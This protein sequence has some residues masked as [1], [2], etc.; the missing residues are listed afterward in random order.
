MATAQERKLKALHNE[1]FLNVRKLS[2][3]GFV[4][5]AVTVLF[6]SALHWMRALAAPEGFQ[7]KGYKDEED[8]FKGTGVFTDEAYE[9]YRQL[10]EDSRVARY[11][12]R[13]FSE[14][15]FEDL[16]QDFFH[17]FRAFIMS[18]LRV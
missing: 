5:W 13:Q 6:Y 12:M 3:S 14:S 16:Q 2:D 17:P 8:V 9:W 10:K 7:I 11:K 4:D 18:M 15:D 1:Q